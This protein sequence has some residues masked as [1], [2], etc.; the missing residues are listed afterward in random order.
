VPP[1]GLLL[2]RDADVSEAGVLHSVFDVSGEP[3]LSELGTGELQLRQNQ[4]RA[5][6]LA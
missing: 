2:A 5:I 4:G 1:D 3:M 6:F